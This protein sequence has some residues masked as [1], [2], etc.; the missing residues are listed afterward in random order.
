MN[1]NR[2]VNNL[3]FHLESGTFFEKIRHTNMIV[4]VFKDIERDDTGAK[5]SREAASLVEAQSNTMLANLAPSEN[6]LKTKFD[7]NYTVRLVIYKEKVWEKEERL[8]YISVQ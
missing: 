4:N 7:T 3:K 5:S 6:A 2:I 1:Y 8:P